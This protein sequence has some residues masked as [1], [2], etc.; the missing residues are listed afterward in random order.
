MIHLIYEKNGRSGLF[1]VA[2]L[3][4]LF[5]V[6]VFGS[7]VG[8]VLTIECATTFSIA[9]TRLGFFAALIRCF[10]YY[11]LIIFFGRTSFGLLAIP[12]VLWLRGFIF[13]ST[14]ASLFCLGEGRL[15]QAAL[16]CGLPALVQLPALFYLASIGFVVAIKRMQR[17]ALHVEDLREMKRAVL[18]AVSAAVLS[19]AV[20]GL[21]N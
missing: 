21:L 13:A 6:Y 3:Y 15:M 14:V 11:G 2:A 18:L 4:F 12:L 5:C 8:G 16:S 10:L 19:A 20:S 9:E 7:A 1:S 17:C